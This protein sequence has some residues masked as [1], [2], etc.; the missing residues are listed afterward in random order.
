M[1]TK[2]KKR[3]CATVHTP[4]VRGA[5]RTEGHISVHSSWVT[6][7]EILFGKNYFLLLRLRLPFVLYSWRDAAVDKKHE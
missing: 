2:K 6:I 1:Y 5:Q 7:F 4:S 3:D